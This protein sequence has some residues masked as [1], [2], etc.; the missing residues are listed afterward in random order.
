MQPWLSR[1][2]P[3]RR[4]VPPP[5]QA[6]GH[7][8]DLG[9]TLP[10]LHAEFACEGAMAESWKRLESLPHFISQ[11]GPDHLYQRLS[12]SI[13]SS[14]SG[15]LV[16]RTRVRH[17]VREDLPVADDPRHSGVPLSSEHV[18]FCERVFIGAFV[19]S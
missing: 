19:R 11:C 14:G 7:A 17:C 8:I 2:K 13:L 6:A 4:N 12:F 9:G 5:I 15:E 1:E 3:L 18:S 16:G 10:A